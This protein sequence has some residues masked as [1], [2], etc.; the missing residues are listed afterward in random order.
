MS[1]HPAA[2]ER[3]MSAAQQ[4][5]ASLGDGA[6]DDLADEALKLDMLEAETDVLEVVKALIRAALDAESMAEA[7]ERRIHDLNAR[8]ARFTVRANSARETVR[9]ML[10]A[11]DVK[12]LV[13]EDFTV[14]LKASPPKVLV[15][16]PN[17][18]PEEYWRVVTTRAPDKPLIKSALD[19]GH[20]V[21][22]AVLSNG[23]A[24]LQIR[25]K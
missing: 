17:D 11:L 3:A 2:V 21:P 1:V 8:A 6:D 16:E 10:E 12:R 9:Q 20:K 19:A 15:P 4:L 24:S 25:T 14:S 22:G 7:V 5:I 23:G 18:L 13:S